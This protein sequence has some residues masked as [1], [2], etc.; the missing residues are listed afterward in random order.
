MNQCSA[1]RSIRELPPKAHYSKPKC[2]SRCHWYTH[3][4]YCP[5]SSH[6]HNTF[7]V[8]LQIIW[9]L[10]STLLCL[11]LTWAPAHHH[12]WHRRGCRT[13]SSTSNEENKDQQ[14]LLLFTS[15]ESQTQWDLPVHVQG[16]FCP[17]GKIMHRSHHNVQLCPL[18]VVTFSYHELKSDYQFIVYWLPLCDSYACV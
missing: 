10:C 4:L 5:S 3:L 7:L 6:P 16:E 11:C 12:S 1:G 13:V 9:W 2:Q 15:P 14:A 8:E 17:E 18:N